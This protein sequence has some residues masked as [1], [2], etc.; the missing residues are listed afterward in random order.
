[1]AEREGGGAS[2]WIAFLAGIILVAIV[3]VGIVAYTGGLPQQRD[4]AAELQIDMP[5][6][7]VNPPD[8]DLPPPQP[9][10]QPPTAEQ[11]SGEPEPAPA[12]P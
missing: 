12:N 11:P 10:Q 6:V 9:L 2:T 4:R 3:A 8:V 5:D 1:M 7:T